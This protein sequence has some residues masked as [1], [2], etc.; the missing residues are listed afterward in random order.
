MSWLYIHAHREK[1]AQVLLFCVFAG[2]HVQ[3]S[4]PLAFEIGHRLVVQLVS[5]ESHHIRK[6]YSISRQGEHAAGSSEISYRFISQSLFFCMAG[7]LTVL[8]G[9]F[10]HG[11]RR[12]GGC[13]RCWDSLEVSG[14]L[15][16]DEG[17]TRAPGNAELL[18]RRCKSG[19]G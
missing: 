14:V 19:C 13:V 5:N 15:L 9:F 18:H 12:A 11:G 1:R 16:W 10:G 7:T 8:L 2:S 3:Y 6:K 4:Y 17:A